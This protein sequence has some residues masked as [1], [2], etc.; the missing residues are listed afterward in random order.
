VRVGGGQ[1]LHVFDGTPI[2][3]DD[4]VRRGKRVGVTPDL[5]EVAAEIQ[6]YEVLY[7]ERLRRRIGRQ[8]G[9]DQSDATAEKLSPFHQSSPVR[10][11]LVK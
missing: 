3:V 11:T 7:R 4:R 5:R 1:R 8:A 9:A 2:G 10:H 6:P